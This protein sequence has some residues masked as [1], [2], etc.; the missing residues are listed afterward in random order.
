MR[1]VHL[2]AGAG[3]M[4]C[5]SC[6]R[7]NTLAAALI[8][9]GHEVLLVP[10]YTP[11]RTDE[12][13]VSLNRVFLGGINV[14]LQ[15]HF[16]FFRKTPAFLDRLLDS[17]PLL[18]LTTRW[19]IRVDPAHL[20]SLTVSILRGTSGFQRKEISKLVRFLREETSPEIISIPNSLL[21]SL[22][23]AIKAELKVP[24]CCTLQ[25]EDLF[26]DG[27]GE[28]YRNEAIRLIREH[29]AHVDA[30]VAVSNFGARQM[31]EYLRL[32]PSRIYIVPLG[33]N[34][35]GYQRRGNPE[36]DPFTVGYLARVAPEKGL[37]VLCES[38]RLLRTRDHL[39]PSRLYAAGYLAPE[40]KP[41][42]ARIQEDFASWGLSSHF[43]Y[44]G[45]L[46]RNGKLA[47]L[48][49]LSVLSVP[50]PYADPKGFSLLEAMASGVPVI[51]PRSGAFTEI[52]E[53]TGG[54]ILV[55]PDSPES[56]AGGILDLWMNAGKRRELGE[57]GYEGVRTHYSAAQMARKTLEIYESLR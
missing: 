39:P 16:E 12:R 34:F 44:H 30:F 17:I 40:H 32:R 3:Q 6:L 4:Y 36:S 37:K 14:Y 13:N 10:T 28:P 33:I 31:T 38:Y 43:N 25:G 15:Q 55:E 18:R 19:G 23:P 21:I 22:A 27:L 24:V 29:A 53:N 45:E 2:T 51:Q 49:S 35:D 5:G 26:L 56:L 20:G 11:T 9:A 42:L 57:R 50:G 52:V 47:F 46:D 41:Y 7:D 54:G 8:N 1:I 48:R